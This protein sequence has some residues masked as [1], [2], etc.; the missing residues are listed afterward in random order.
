M[1][2]QLL[3]SID[4]F[5]DTYTPEV[6]GGL[7]VAILLL[8][9]RSLSVLVNN[10][11][12]RRK[13]AGYVGEYYIYSY[14][15]TGVGKIVTDGLIIKPSLGRLVVVLGSAQVYSYTGTME[16]SER[17]IYVTVHG[18]N[19]TEQVH[20]IFHSPLHRYIR[21][22]VGV[23]LAISPIDEPAA[24]Y[25][26]LSD[27][28]MPIELVE[29]EFERLDNYNRSKILCVSRDMHLFFDNLD[30]E[31][32]GNMYGEDMREWPRNQARK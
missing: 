28:P 29:K 3:P 27:E 2:L 13:Y 14:S 22:L 8:L 7:L 17:N 4:T 1:E 21:K 18:E 31:L 15:S 25:C 16:V 11:K 30:D 5:I 23:E 20:F 26:L 12:T 9:L 6:V 24:K 10:W 32:L 19:H